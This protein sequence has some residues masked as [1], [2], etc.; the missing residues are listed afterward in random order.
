MLRLW[1]APWED[2]DGDLHEESIVHVI[3][4]TGR[5]LIEHVRPNRRAR[6]DAVVPPAAPTDAPTPQPATGAP[7]EP[8]RLSVPPPT[9]TPSTRPAQ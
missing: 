6:F 8:E 4:D 7:I 5:W 1:I 2:R 9:T 3:V